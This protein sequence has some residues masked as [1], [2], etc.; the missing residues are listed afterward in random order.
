MTDKVISQYSAVTTPATGS[1]SYVLQDPSGTPLD[2]YITYDNLKAW[3]LAGGSGYPMCGRL[4]LSN[5]NAIPT[6]D[7]AAATSVYWVNYKGN[8]VSLYTAGAWKFYATSGVNVSMSG[9]TA[10][11]PYDIFMYDSGGS[12]AIEGLVWTSDTA[13]AT[14]LTTQD[15]VLVKSGAT[16]R[17]YLGTIRTTG[18][19]GQSEDSE[20]RRLC[21]NYY[22]R[23]PRRLLKADATSHSY[24]TGTYRQWNNGAGNQVDMVIGYQEDALEMSARGMNTGAALGRIGLKMD[25]TAS[26]DF[27][28]YTLSASSHVLGINGHYALPAVGY[29]YIAAIE[30]GVASL[31]ESSYQLDGIVLA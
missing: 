25:A 9:W 5:G 11:R 22:N 19:T 27:E 18:T 20:A 14:A 21:W 31:T 10:S 30:Y 1:I 6:T 12:P 7:V 16:D 24:T 15:G 23:V 8:V 17:R 28:F 13:R 3:V 29:H 2:K 4:S 26:V